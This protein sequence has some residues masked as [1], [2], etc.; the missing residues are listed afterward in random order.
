MINLLSDDIAKVYNMRNAIEANKECYR[1]YSDGAF[2]VPLRTVIKGEYGNFCFMPSYCQSLGVAGIK[3]VNIMPHNSEI[4]LPGTIGEIMLI[5]A[6]TGEIRATLDGTY[7][8]AVRTAAASGAAFDLLA[9]KDARIGALVGTGSQAMYQLEAMLC[10]RELSEVRVAARNFD[11]TQHFVKEA[12]DTLSNYGVNIIACETADE[13][14]SDA[15]LVI[16]VTTATSPVCSADSFKA[17]AVISAVGSYTYD[18]QELPPEIF[19][20]A[21]KIYFDSKDAVLEESGDILRPLDDGTLDESQFT[22]E[23]GELINGKIPGRESKD[24]II[25][26][27]NVGF[28][29]LDLYASYDIFQHLH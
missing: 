25:V 6:K 11:K 3:V 7:V 28:G 10:N 13:A 23:I 18:M 1:L 17:G 27:E 12:N 4:G 20:K 8:T 5:D 29:A 2:E 14:V 19:A 26:F 15:D 22:G 9:N 24:E 21:G 16:L